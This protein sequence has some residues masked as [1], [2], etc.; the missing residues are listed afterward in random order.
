MSRAL[1][2]WEAPPPAP[3][4]EPL[5]M[6]EAMLLVDVDLG[7]FG[8]L[9]AGPLLGEEIRAA[10]AHRDA[11]RAWSPPPFVS[12]PDIPVEGHRDGLSWGRIDVSEHAPAWRVLMTT[13]PVSVS[14]GASPFLRADTA[15]FQRHRFRGTDAAVFV[16]DGLDVERVAAVLPVML[17]GAS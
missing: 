4:P 1:F 7:T 10:K 9:P 2:V 12:Q 6:R 13:E 16:H 8:D 17:G 14:Y 3:R 5:T 11:L 15:V